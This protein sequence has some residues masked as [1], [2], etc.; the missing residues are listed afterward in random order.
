MNSRL[1]YKND[2]GSWGV[3]GMNEKNQDEKMYG[4]AWK[5][6][7]YEEC[8]MTP[9]QLKDMLMFEVKIGTT[10]QKYVVYGVCNGHCIAQ[11]GDEYAVW[12]VDNDKRG[13]HCGRYFI[14][15]EEAERRFCE[16]CFSFFASDENEP[17]HQV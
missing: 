11:R 14:S 16:L 4:V 10:I 9:D 17:K 8:G 6:K 1:T 3:V 2:D 12:D 13:V 7:D 15:K 5:L